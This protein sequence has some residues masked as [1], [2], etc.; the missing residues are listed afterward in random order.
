MPEASDVAVLHNFDAQRFELTV[1]SERAFAAY[2]LHD[3]AIVFTHTEVPPALEGRGIG[4]ALAR[5]ALEYAR[6]EGLAVVAL[7]PFIAGYIRRHPQYQRLVRA[8][9]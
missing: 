6:A 2:R 5:A 3:G 1:E 7:C 8:S 4:S 9:R